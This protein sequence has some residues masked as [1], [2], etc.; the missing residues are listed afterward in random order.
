M[1][2]LSPGFTMRR[3]LNMI[4]GD[5][6]GPGDPFFANVVLLAPYSSGVA[7]GSSILTGAASVGINDQSIYR[8]PQSTAAGSQQAG[9]YWFTDTFS[10][11]AS[12]RRYGL[13]SAGTNT[14]GNLGFAPANVPE[15][16]MGLGDF[17]IEADGY[18]GLSGTIQLALYGAGATGV[19]GTWQLGGGATAP[20]SYRL[21]WYADGTNVP[22]MQSAANVWNAAALG[23]EWHTVAYSRVAGV[24]FLFADGVLVATGA[25]ATDYTTVSAGPGTA[26]RASALNPWKG[27]IANVRLTKG[28]GRYTANYIPPTGPYPTHG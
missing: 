20:T 6:G 28:V 23:A 5:L 15:F 18:M 17:T 11:L 3:A 9:K 22:L 25:D 10:S 14:D 1:S 16:Q 7:Q 4:L 19:A 8:H 26:T 12:V 21:S 24:G 13:S 2:F 27:Y